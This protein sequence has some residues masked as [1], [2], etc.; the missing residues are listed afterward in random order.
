[1]YHWLSSLFLFLL[2][3]STLSAVDN[4]GVGIALFTPPKGWSQTDTT[5]LPPSVKVM[6]V[7]KGSGAFPPSMNLSTQSYIGTLK[8]YLKMI[9][10]I[11][12][13]QGYEWKDLGNIKTDAGIASLSQ[14]DT[15]NEWGIIR[16]M[17]VVLLKNGQIYILTGAA[18]K[19]D[20]SKFYKSFFDAFHSLK[21]N[22]DIY[23]MVKEPKQRLK[24]QETIDTLN[25][26]WNSKIT[27]EQQANPQED[28][29]SIKERVFNGEV[30]Q[31]NIWKPF[32]EDIERDYR[33]MGQDWQN[34]VITTTEDQLFY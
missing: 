23:E 6:V 29:K 3:T 15:K 20:F 18:L 34:F 31:K 14:V 1:M 24:L 21:I 26:K 32:K 7:G 16:Q 11:N 25:N 28:V 22:N 13:S 27:Q 9:K 30:F 19:E 17:H 12:E 2:I 10:S 5:A 8:Q 33:D 4:S